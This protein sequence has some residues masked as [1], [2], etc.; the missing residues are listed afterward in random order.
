MHNRFAK[1][2]TFVRSNVAFS[3]V[4]KGTLGVIDEDYGT[5]VMVAWNLPDQPL[6]RG[7][8]AWDGRPACSPG[9]P[10]RDGFDKERELVYL[11]RVEG[12]CSRCGAP[13]A[14]AAG[15]CDECGGLIE[16]DPELAALLGP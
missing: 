5:G 2:G 16:T 15:T 9:A 13:I 3:G 7:Y 1:V 8:R 10:L 12:R 6:P 4:P 14:N 11:A